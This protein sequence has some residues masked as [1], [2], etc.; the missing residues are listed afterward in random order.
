MI[1]FFRKIR[2]KLI[3]EGKTANYLK[4]AI[5]EIVL[6]VIGILIALSINNWNTANN[7][8]K[9]LNGHLETILENISNNKV[10]LHELLK[11]RQKSQVLSTQMIN[12]YKSKQNANS[13]TFV[14]AL[15]S[16]VIESKFD[17]DLSG[18]ERL[19]S[20]T[21]YKSETIN[22][23]RDLTL[24][25]N[26]IIEEIKFTEMRHNEFSENMENGLWKNGFYDEVWPHLRAAIDLEKF[27]KPETEIDLIR[28]TN[29]YGEIKGL[30]LR[31]EFVN[32][33][34]L[35]LYNTLL[36]KGE[37]ITTTVNNYLTSAN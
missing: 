21:M 36:S 32:S 7:E 18:F 35:V 12:A 34:I 9:I 6:V 14:E 3:Q 8:H 17:P 28:V 20:S 1:K 10:Q 22:T 37:E 26:K 25:Y 27:G 15:L 31:N 11:H 30:F 13:E 4:Y 24:E 2:Q 29:E 16:I 5:G 19:K 33:K 23:I